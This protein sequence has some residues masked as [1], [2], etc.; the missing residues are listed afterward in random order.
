V[1]AEAGIT[2]PVAFQIGHE[3]AVEIVEPWFQ[4]FQSAQKLEAVSIGTG[5]DF[6]IGISTSPNPVPTPTQC[7]DRVTE[8]T[9]Q[10]NVI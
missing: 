3:T 1:A 6:S 5:V 9:S 10:S 4:G 2:S 8:L 7:W